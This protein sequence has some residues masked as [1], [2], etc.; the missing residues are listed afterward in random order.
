LQAN[1]LV[2]P[3]YS[4]HNDEIQYKGHFYLSNQ[5][6]LKS[7]VLYELHAPP[8]V[9]NSGSTKTHDQ[10]KRYFLWD[11]M[12]HDIH[13]FVE[14]C[15]VFQCNKGKIVKSLSTL[16]SLLIPPAIWRDIS[17]DFIMDLHKLGSKLV[18]MVVVDHIS[19]YV[20]LCSLQHPFT[21]S[22]LAQLFMD[23]VFKL[24]CMLHSIVFYG[25][26]TITENFWQEMFRVQGTQL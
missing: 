20:H 10:V 13:N 21:A 18:I 11:G 22:T 23:Q 1:S 17:M 8:I 5:S 2:S 6:Q 3:G 4:L 12:K 16:Q 25:N 9:G 26:P 7:K 15:D 24:H 14:E 19:K